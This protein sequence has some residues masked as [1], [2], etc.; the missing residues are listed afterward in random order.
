MFYGEENEIATKSEIEE[1]LANLNI[2]ANQ[3]IYQGKILEYSHVEFVYGKIEN[4][5]RGFSGLSAALRSTL[6]LNEAKAM[7]IE[8]LIGQR[9]IVDIKENQEINL[10]LFEEPE[11]QREREENKNKIKIQIENNLWL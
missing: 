4:R 8:P 11:L 6:G 1:E 3:N 10:T 9:A 2:I 5:S 7:K